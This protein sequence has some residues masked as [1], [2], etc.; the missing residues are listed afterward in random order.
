MYPLASAGDAGFFEQKAYV[1][2]CW[3][4]HML[5]QHVTQGSQQ[6]AAP[7]SQRQHQPREPLKL[8]LSMP[9][10]I[11]VPVHFLAAEPLPVL[12]GRAAPRG[13]V[14]AEKPRPPPGLPP[15]PGLTEPLA[16]DESWPCGAAAAS[17]RAAVDGAGPTSRAVAACPPGM[18][19]VSLE[20]RTCELLWCIDKLRTKLRYS[21]GFAVLSPL[22]TVEGLPEVRLMFAPGKE[23]KDFPGARQLRKRSGLQAGRTFGAV[24]LKTGS[25]DLAAA[26]VRFQAFFK[27]V[28][29][30]LAIDCDLADRNVHSCQMR[31]DWRDHLNDG[32]DD[33]EIRVR[34]AW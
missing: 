21:R 12:L 23:W 9:K 16:S 17:K 20:R 10:R 26:S 2:A 27:D 1:E 29:T 33:L 4:S 34:L 15:P 24:S 22:V 13:M 6:A 18:R 7:R 14:A 25:S 19:I 32:C 5:Q 8:D 28:S 31:V 11:E 30:G 3:A